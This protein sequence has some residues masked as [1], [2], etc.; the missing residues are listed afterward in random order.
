MRINAD[1]HLIKVRTG[2]YV[3]P[4]KEA[5]DPERGNKDTFP[6]GIDG[7]DEVMD[8]GFKEG[9][10][11]VLSGRSGQGKTLTALNITKNLYDAGVPTLFFT[12]EV[13]VDNVYND[14]QKMGVEEDPAIF[15]PKKNVSG[16]INWINEKIDEAVKKYS[17]KVVIIDHLDFITADSK[18]DDYRRN[19]ITNIVARLKDIA[20]NKRLVIILLAHVVKNS[21]RTLTNESLADSRAIANLADYVLFVARETDENDLAMNNRGM[22]KLT[23]NRFTGKHTLIPFEVVN[24]IIKP[25]ELHTMG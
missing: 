12:F 19:Q 23:K 9:D 4:I 16:N 13:V 20:I 22:L 25:Y 17:P 7:L 8:G 14:L 6:L 5:L 10:L 11:M 21:E 1:D 2:D 18:N 3:V 15:T 24:K